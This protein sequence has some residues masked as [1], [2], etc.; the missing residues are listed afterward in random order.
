MRAARFFISPQDLWILL[1]GPDAPRIIDTRRR[2]VFSASPGVLPTSSWH[3][4]NDVASCMQTLDRDLPVVLLCQEGHARSQTAAACLREQGFEASVLSGGY[5]AWIEAGLPLVSKA[6]LETLCRIQADEWT[7]LTHLRANVVVPGPVA[8]PLR[9]RTHPGEAAAELRSA[10][11]LA[12]L[13]LYLLGPD[14][15]GVSGR[16]FY[17]QG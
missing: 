9:A 7:H 1:G 4:P 11:S 17:V 13:Y 3:D 12:P 5:E 10:D 14:S 16:T 8:S 6:A 2:E 15:I